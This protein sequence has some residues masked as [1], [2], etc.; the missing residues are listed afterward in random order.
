MLLAVCFLLFPL[1]S[2]PVDA[3]TQVSEVR[4]W[5]AQDYTRLTI[6]S[7]A[8]VTHNLFTIRSPERLV[9]DLENIELTSALN[10]LSAK[11][12]ASDPYIKQVRVGH[13]KPG[14]VRLVLDL[15]TEVKPQVFT[16][17]PVGD[18]GHR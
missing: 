16:L 8:P 14:V 7:N 10:E 6:E 18:Y 11:I 1:I 17:R 3:A 15:K 4:V 12:S 9:L 2:F 5:P 13:F